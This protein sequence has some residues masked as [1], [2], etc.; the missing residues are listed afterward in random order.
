MGKSFEDYM[1]VQEANESGGKTS[2]EG[3]GSDKDWRKEHIMLEKGFI[4]PS[5]MKPVIEAFLNSGNIE[6]MADTSGK[7]PKMP[8]KSLFLVGGPVRD[9]LKGKSIKD[10]DLATNA[11]PE[12]VAHI[13]HSGG[14][15]V[16]GKRSGGEVKP[17]FDRS[18]KE[19]APLNIT[20]KPEITRPGDHLTWFLKGRDASQDSKP[21]VISAVVKGEEFEI[22]T[23]RKDAK[24]TDGQAAVDF[25]D[26]PHDDAARRDLTINALYIEL[27]KP[28]GENNKLFDPTRRGWH[29][30]M[31]SE[32]RTVGK[33][34]DRF[35]EDK[36]RVLRA[37]RFHCR[38]GKG[39]KMHS[40]I[41]KAIPRFKNLQGVAL[42]R[43]REEFL[44]GLLHD[45][46]DP[47]CYLSIYARTG[48]LEKVLPGVDVTT[49]VPEQFATKRDKPLA[50]AWMLQNNDSDKVATVLGSVRGAENTPTGWSSEDRNSVLYLLKLKEFDPEDISDLVKNR[51]GSG[52]NPDQIRDWVEMFNITDKLGR[53]RSGRPQWAQHIKAFADFEP[54][55]R[56]HITWQEK[57]DC[58]ECKGTG[59]GADK[60]K[61]QACRG[62]KYQKG[63]VHPTIQQAGYANVHPNDRGNVVKDLNRANLSAKFK[64][65]LP[66]NE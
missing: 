44:K 51:K 54:D 45:E 66:K 4:P 28:D 38:F 25:V 48:L 1:L 41:E 18:G 56:D 33:A 12:Q 40:D 63:D 35:G 47:K 20:F 53:K 39:T 50:L 37:V 46:V 6:L 27:T 11:T 3:G 29:D 21:F 60:L 15:K 58:P 13:L 62:K 59:A 2:G 32:V 26:N 17:H 24:V 23:F 49:D 30:A 43:V 8:K 16:R 14:F 19:G 55:P 64:E 7:A 36:L 42:E 57:L 52:L 34:E 61:C 65:L 5:N 22:A 9:F 10:Y 31:N